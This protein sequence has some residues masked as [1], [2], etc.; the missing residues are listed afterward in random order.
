[1]PDAPTAPRVGYCFLRIWPSRHQ[2]SAAGERTRV[3]LPLR[4]LAGAPCVQ[5]SGCSRSSLATPA[6]ISLMFIMGQRCAPAAR[7]TIRLS[8]MRR[9]RHFFLPAG[10]HSINGTRIVPRTARPIQ[11]TANSNE[12]VQIM[13]SGTW[14]IVLAAGDG[15]GAGHPGYDA[16]TATRSTVSRDGTCPAFPHSCSGDARTAPQAGRDTLVPAPIERAR[17]ARQVLARRTGFS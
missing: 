8:L 4:S 2:D 1:M 6:A 15:D 10:K 3:E 16:G 14:I 5:R 12:G 7:R 17:S 11:V 13:Q 9:F